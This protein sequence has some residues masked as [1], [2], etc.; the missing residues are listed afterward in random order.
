MAQSPIT[1]DVH[2]AL[3]VHHHLGAQRAFD[4][5]LV[6]NDAVDAMHISISQSVYPGIGIN[7]GFFDNPLCESG[8]DSVNIG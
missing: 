3:D 7:A 6:L 4:L 2:Q 8:S 5:E 1:A